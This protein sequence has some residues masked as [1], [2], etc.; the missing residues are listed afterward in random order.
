MGVTMPKEDSGCTVV[1]VWVSRGSRQGANCRQGFQNMNASQAAV[2]R[3]RTPHTPPVTYPPP[4]QSQV[5]A[6][7]H[8][9]H[10]AVLCAS[11]NDSGL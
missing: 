7:Q 3:T 8:T 6:H 4:H 9:N 5:A 10:K 1:R 11:F 2:T